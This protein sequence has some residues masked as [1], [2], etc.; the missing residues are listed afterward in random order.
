MAYR[1]V[2]QGPFGYPVGKRGWSAL[3]GVLVLE[4]ALVAARKGALLV[5]API[6]L[7]TI[8]V[9]A[10]GLLGMVYLVDLHRFAK[11]ARAIG[12][13]ILDEIPEHS[14]YLG[15]HRARDRHHVFYLS[16]KLIV[17]AASTTLAA[18][19]LA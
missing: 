4:G 5:S 17:V 10:A 7:L 11:K 1:V 18:V 2:R 3:Q 16:V 13:K 8:V 15:K 19:A 9:A 12:D 6:G 14:Y